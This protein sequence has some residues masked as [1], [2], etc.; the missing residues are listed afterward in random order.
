MRIVASFWLGAALAWAQG[1]TARANAGWDPGAELNRKLADE[2]GKTFKLT[3]EFRNRW[4]ARTGVNFGRASN[5]ENPLFRTR[6]GAEWKPLQWLKLSAMG[7]DSRSPLYGAQPPVTARDGMDVQ[8]SYI[9]LFPD[10]KRGF[11]FQAGRQMTVM[12]EGRIIGVP[13]WNNTSRTYDMGRVY[14]RLPRARLE[15]LMVSIVKVRPDEYNRP[16]LGDRL[17]GMYNSFPNL[18]A[19]ATVDVYIL[20]RSQNRPGG[21]AGA[22]TLG[23]NAYGGRAA[24][25]LV[26]KWKYSVEGMVQAGHIGSRAQRGSGLVGNVSHSVPL[27]FP[28]DLAI[29]YKY[30]SGS[31]DPAGAR[32]GTFDQLYAANHDR[33][34]HAD[35]FGWRNIHNLRSLDTLRVGKNL[36]VNFMYNNLWLASEKD[37][38]YSGPGVAIAQS[39]RGVAGRHV[40]Q[41]TDLFLV[42]KWGG[43]Q[44]GAGFAHLFKGEF[45][46]NTTPGVNTRYLY[47]FQS[48]SF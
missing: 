14:Y 40:G 23:I 37:A 2:T 44:F 9:E 26:G 17:W 21:F 3:F 29:E 16:G 39:I 4:E 33:F 35:L 15:F 19:K 25:P 12:G 42:R 41:E 34:G 48:Y 20:R 45:L 8:E 22:G 47:V 30:A 6:I 43:L 7:Q 1:V 46:R 31:K 36:A 38:L 27:K 5:L 10:R 32:S 11:G 24:G 18:L 13:Q 28:L